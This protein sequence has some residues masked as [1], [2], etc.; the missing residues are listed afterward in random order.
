MYFGIIE[1]RHRTGTLARL[2]GRENFQYSSTN[3]YANDWHVIDLASRAVG[4]TFLKWLNK[5]SDWAIANP[6]TYAQVDAKLSPL[7]VNTSKSITQRSGIWQF[8]IKVLL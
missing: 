3:G 4:G 8:S 2:Q 7:P 1:A 5:A 6:D